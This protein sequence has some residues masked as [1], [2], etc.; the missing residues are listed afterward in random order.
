MQNLKF[1]RTKVYNLTEAV[2]SIRNA[3]QSWVDSDSNIESDILGQKDLA[4]AQKL[5]RSGE[6]HRKFLRQIFITTYIS[7]PAYF[8]N[9]LDQYKIGTVTNSTSKMHKMLAK[10]FLP[11]NF[12]CADMSLAVKRKVLWPLIDALNILRGEYL[13]TKDKEIWRAILQL[14]PQSYIQGRTL[15]LNY[16]V[17]F[18]IYRQRKGHKLSEWQEF[19]VWCERLPYWTKFFKGVE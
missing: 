3:M 7:A 15:T 17:A 11:S 10:K 12:A 4:L 2:Y 19:R 13:R 16:E 1:E 6:S 18:N 14:L 8:W 5:I 9:Q